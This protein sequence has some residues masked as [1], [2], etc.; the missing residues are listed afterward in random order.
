MP[1]LALAFIKCNLSANDALQ[2]YRSVFL[3]GIK[4]ALTAASIPSNDLTKA[5]S[6]IAQTVL[7]LLGYNRHIPLAIVY[8]SPC[9]GGIGLQDL[10]LEQGI[11]HTIF[12]IGH[13]RANSDIAKL[14]IILIE[15]YT[16]IA[17]ITYNILTRPTKIRY[18][19]APW[20]EIITNF[21]QHTDT[22]ITT[23]LVSTPQ[24]LRQHDRSIMEIASQLEFSDNNMETIN[25]CRLWLQITTLAEICTINGAELLQVAIDGTSNYD[26][27]PS[28]WIYSISRLR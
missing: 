23:T 8:A 18:V 11:L 10:H 6:L 5:Q 24:L 12:L 22:F 13:F 20:L 7:P 1:Q 21:L 15:T 16:Q 28:L 26:G 4:Y 2:G 19:S 3:P 25:N 14:L 9:V 17:G 27:K